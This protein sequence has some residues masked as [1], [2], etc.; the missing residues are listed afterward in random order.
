MR[1]VILAA[2]AAAGLLLATGPAAAQPN[3]RN[4][5]DAGFDKWDKNKDGHLDADELAKAYRGPN[6]TAAAH[7]PGDNPRA[8]AQHPDHLFLETWDADKDGR[9]SRAEFDRYEAKTLADLRATANR[10]V[11]YS[12]AG[13]P[14]YR[15]P[16]SHRG[17]S[18]RGRGYG[19]NPYAAQLRYQHR[20]LDQQRRLYAANARYAGYSPYARGGY[21]GAMRHGGRRR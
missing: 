20:T 6:A 13:R 21:R 2:G 16:Y 4:P 9:I 10:Q 5:L 17:Y 1:G 11:N 8:D 18:S 12:R 19:T 15:R 3:G 14:S 7:K